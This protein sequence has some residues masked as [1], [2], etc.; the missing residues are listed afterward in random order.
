M[1]RVHTNW[2]LENPSLSHYMKNPV[3]LRLS[4]VSD[5]RDTICTL[6]QQQAI[7][8][9]LGPSLELCCKGVVLSI[10]AVHGLAGQLL[11]LY[12]SP[13][14]GNHGTTHPPLTRLTELLLGITH[15][16]S[17]L[18]PYMR[19]TCPQ[20]DRVVLMIYVMSPDQILSSFLCS[21]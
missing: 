12:S 9:I 1:T 16:T 10:T 11:W 5:S 18:G 7:W 21:S 6:A 2:A 8:T 20:E 13:L 17:H 19:L 4:P 3:W 15:H 14:K